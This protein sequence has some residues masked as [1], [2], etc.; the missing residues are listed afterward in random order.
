VAKLKAADCANNKINTITGGGGPK[1]PHFTHTKRV[2]IDVGILQ[3][4]GEL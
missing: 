3:V 1:P 2:Y 4:K